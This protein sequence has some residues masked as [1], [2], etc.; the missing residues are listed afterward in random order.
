MFSSVDDHLVYH[1]VADCKLLPPCC[2]RTARSVMA[3]KFVNSL[4]ML[5]GDLAKPTI[6]KADLWN[7]GERQRQSLKC[8]IDIN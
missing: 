6:L 8:Q 2:S 7:A 4:N 3:M 1:L 5:I